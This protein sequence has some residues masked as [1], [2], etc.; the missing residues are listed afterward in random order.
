M[1]YHGQSRSFVVRGKE[2]L[3]KGLLSEWQQVVLDRLHSSRDLLQKHGTEKLIAP[4]FGLFDVQ[5]GIHVHDYVS[6]RTI[7]SA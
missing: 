2:E 3:E 1:K 5:N 6:P 4:P 7:V